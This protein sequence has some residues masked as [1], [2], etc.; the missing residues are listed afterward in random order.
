MRIITDT[1]VLVRAV[2]GDNEVQSHTSKLALN[3]AGQVIIGRHVFCELVW[4]LSQ[5][6]KLPKAEIVRTIHGFLDAENVVTDTAAVEAGLQAMAAGADFAD[7]VIAYEG[8]WLG[9]EEFASFDKKAVA[10]IAKQGLRTRL[11]A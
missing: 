10:A 11:L 1:N 6:Y 5:T 3:S 2:L 8:A 7:G 4:V 9:G